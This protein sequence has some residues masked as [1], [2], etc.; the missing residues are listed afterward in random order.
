MLLA[1]TDEI[2]WVLDHEEAIAAWEAGHPP[3]VDTRIGPATAA[4]AASAA[5]RR[6][7][8]RR[9]RNPARPVPSPGP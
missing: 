6:T 7:C 1:G 9:P 2:G 8:P 4:Y 5:R 3:R